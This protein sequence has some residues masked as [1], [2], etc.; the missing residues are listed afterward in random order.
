MF[1]SPPRWGRCT[2]AQSASFPSHQVVRSCRVIYKP[3]NWLLW[4]SGSGAAVMLK[5]PC[6]LAQHFPVFPWLLPF[7][8]SL[9]P[10]IQSL[11]G[12]LRTS[13]DAIRKENNTCSV[14]QFDISIPYRMLI[15]YS[16]CWWDFWSLSIRRI[17]NAII[18]VV[19]DLSFHPKDNALNLY[20]L[21]KKKRKVVKIPH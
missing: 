4:P 12:P 3:T 8:F 14:Y 1:N 6:R 2:G 16:C 19:V 11:P 20:S 18:F 9:A 10:R 15:D 7:S 21:L 5:S 17:Y 13:Q